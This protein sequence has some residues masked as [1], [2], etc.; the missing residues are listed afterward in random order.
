[1]DRIGQAF[2]TARAEGRAALI[3]YVTAGYPTLEQ[4][5]GLVRS[6]TRAG[7]DVIEIGIPFSDPLADGPILQRAATEALAAG[8]RVRD[9]LRVVSQISTEA[10]PLVFLTYI[11][12]VFRY[13]IEE[14]A[15]DSAQAGVAGWIIPDLPW[16]ESRAVRDTAQQYGIALIPL[17]APTSTDQHLKAIAHGHGFVYGVSVTGVTG[18]R[19]AVD[20]GVETLVARV[21]NFVDLPVAVGF[22][23]STPAQAREVGRVADGVIVGSALVKT[24]ADHRDACEEA[25]YQFVR[26]LREALDNLSAKA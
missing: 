9:V 2:R 18:V 22:G 21:K 15:R 13:G 5:P 10:P 19:D 26:G 1:M 20:T 16:L 3:P 11:N 14:F 8:T 23:I 25:A 4:L 12:P 7:A 17:A 24:I 6:L